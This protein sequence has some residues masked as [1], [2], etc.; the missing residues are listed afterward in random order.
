MRPEPRNQRNWLPTG[1]VAAAVALAG[2]ALQLPS[3]NRGIVPLDEGHMAAVVV[4]LLDGE[5]LYRDVDTGLF[6]GI[7]YLC[8]GLFTLFERDLLVTRWAQLVLNVSIASTLWFVGRRTAS[9]V[10]AMLPA[11]LYLGLVA[12]GF[13]VLA[14]LNYSAV[15]CAFALFALLL[16]LRYLEFGRAW[17]GLLCGVALA[18]C[19]L[20][21]QNFGAL[22]LIGVGLAF[23]AGR[24][25]S[26]I[27][28][29]PAWRAL[30]PILLGGGTLALMVAAYF[31]WLGTFGELIHSTLVEVLGAQM[32][33]YRAPYPPLLGPHPD[34]DP[35]FS[36]VY[37][38]PTV[39]NYALGQTTLFGLTMSAPVREMIIRL[40]YSLPLVLLAGAPALWVV[41]RRASPRRRTATR[42]VAIMAPV[43]FLGIY[44][45]AIW[46]HLAY[47]LAPVLLLAAPIGEQLARRAGSSRSLA[48]RAIKVSAV[49][50]SLLVLGVGARISS[51]VAGWFSEPTGV[52]HATLSVMPHQASALR[53]AATFVEACSDPGDFIF[54]APDIPVVYL[55]TERRNPTPYALLIPGAVDGQLVVERLEEHRP[56]CVVYNPRMF[57]QFPPFE[58]L[59][60]EVKRYLLAHYEKQADLGR[61]LSQ[62]H[63]LV[64]RESPSH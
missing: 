8:A 53:D 63:G 13:P 56:R 21:K 39:W 57:P 7:Y 34:S 35:L 49:T 41:T 52:P 17:E 9:P 15:A 28:P 23:W 19:V 51:D 58:E 30:M 37:S 46:S 5:L 44:P 12:V 45:E 4:R 47:V 61:P 27:E 6:P 3:F 64:R 18:C 32:E 62:W 50:V 11:A 55:V 25:R 31:L 43:F 2:V 40:S 10:F 36:L 14:M 29:R 20:V 60:P 16:L 38:P 22:A 54:V 42:A 33:A 59:F 24:A 1:L 26:A 48:R